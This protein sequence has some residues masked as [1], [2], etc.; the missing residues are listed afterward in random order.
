MTALVL[1]TQLL[2][3]NTDQ[4]RAADE[5]RARANIAHT[6]EQLPLGDQRQA[7]LDAF[8]ESK[9]SVAS[10]RT[11]QLEFYHKNLVIFYRPAENAINAISVRGLPVRYTQDQIPLSKCQEIAK[12]CGA[13]MLPMFDHWAAE[14]AFANSETYRIL[15]TPSYLGIET[16]ELVEVNVRRADGMP[17][18]IS[19]LSPKMDYSVFAGQKFI[20]KDA[21]LRIGLDSYARYQPFASWTV[22]SVRLVLGNPLASTGPGTASTAADRGYIERK[23]AL[24]LY[25]IIVSDGRSSMAVQHIFVHAVEGR[26]LCVH[27]LQGFGGQAIEVKLPGT[28]T[29]ASIVKTGKKVKL[30]PDPTKGD[31]PPET[32]P[33][34]ALR[35]GS[36]SY[37]ARLDEGRKLV[38]ISDGRK[39]AAYRAERFEDVTKAAVAPASFGK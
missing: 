3:A 36:L 7:I 29:K 38:W 15:A 19:R 30:V 2:L 18:E 27:E 37:T 23:V 26:T 20:S 13:A 25:W 39:W 4:D 35:T 1:A 22:A 8:T 16:R 5:T 34:V 9:G 33:V 31:A 10:E 32:A 17:L 11:G 12:E 28:E 21:A 14:L 24:P 6:L